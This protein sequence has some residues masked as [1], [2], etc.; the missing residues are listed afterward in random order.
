MVFRFADVNFEIDFRDDRVA[1]K[2]KDYYVRDG[3]PD[4]C[5]RV[6]DDAYEKMFS[7]YGMGHPLYTE[8]LALSEVISNTLLKSYNGFLFHSSAIAYKGNGVLFSAVSGTGKSTHAKFWK[9]NFGDDVQYVNDDK[10][11]VREIDGKFFVF[12]N[13]W[14]GKERLSNNVKIPL[15]AICFIERGEKTEILPISVPS[16][17]VSFYNQSFSITEEDMQDKFLSLIDRMLKS[18]K[19]VKLIL[20][21]DERSPLKVLEGLKE[22]LC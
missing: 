19:I 6:D 15:K 12:G 21:L 16:A 20:P 3:K 18:V 13:P 8:F 10:P 14:N 22:V 2:F 1:S 11:F 4:A 7:S 9:Q 5:I 17:V